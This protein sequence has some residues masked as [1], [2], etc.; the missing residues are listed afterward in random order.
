MT[1]KNIDKDCLGIAVIT[2]NEGLYI[3]EWIAYHLKLGVSCIRIYDN[4]SI[5]DTKKRA[6]GMASQGN[7]IIID[8]PDVGRDFNETQ[9][10]A[11]EDAAQFFLG[12]VKFVAFIDVDE[13]LVTDEDHCILKILNGVHQ[14]VGAI[15]CQQVVFGSSGNL[16][17]VNDLVLSRF[18]TCAPESYHEN[19]YFKSIA[20]P[21]NFIAM[22]TVHSVKT[23]G[24]YVFVDGSLLERPT[25]NP[26]VATRVVHRP[27][28]L[29][30]YLLKSLGEFR[31]KRQRFEHT[32]LSNSLKERYS[33]DAFFGRNSRIN[34]VCNTELSRYRED[35]LRTIMLARSTGV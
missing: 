25:D 17:W 6:F 28:R 10:M 2:K 33:D 35:V 9:K 13:F 34:V 24:N 16:E 20:R 27:L 8:W 23:N 32:A 18:T 4:G 12:K 19:L 14:S 22:E 7:V 31:A 15:A 26:R 1:V 11:Y 3:E 29:H 30:H 21:E 5:D